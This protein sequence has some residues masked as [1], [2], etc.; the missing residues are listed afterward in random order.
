MQ[1]TLKTLLMA[2]ALATSTAMISAPAQAQIPAFLPAVEE[3]APGAATDVDGTYVVSTINKRITIENGRAYV[4]DPWTHAFIL[5]VEPRMVTLQNFRQ[6]GPDTYEADDL[7][8]MGKV[9]FHRQ[10]NGTL[11][12]V[13]QGALGTAKY[14]LVPT[15]YA[16]APGD[17]TPGGAPGGDPITEDPGLGAP[18]P[19]NDPWVYRLHVSGGECS[20]SKFGRL[21]YNGQVRMTIMDRENDKRETK[22]RNFRV[23]CTRNGDRTQSYR[24]YDNGPGA[25]TLIT[26]PGELAFSD[27]RIAGRANGGIGGLYFGNDKNDVL[28]KARDRGRGVRVGDR[29]TDKVTVLGDKAKLNFTVTLERVK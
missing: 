3:V 13:V 22:N 12:G 6:T 10:P 24:F 21:K 18:P 15:D 20:G 2:T 19:S 25:F 9:V 7:P 28:S 27:L 23:E 4:I 29:F 26:P 1:N 8:M 16:T 5:K 14:A 17:G 11:Q